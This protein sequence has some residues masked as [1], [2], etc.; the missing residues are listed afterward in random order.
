MSTLFSDK[1][2]RDVAAAATGRIERRRLLGVLAGVALLP[3]TAR[4]A[5][6]QP[7]AAP[8]G[9]ISS[10]ATLRDWSGQTPVRYPD[11]DIIALDPS[12][13][14]CMQFNSAI[15]RLH[16][17]TLWAEGPAWNGVGRYLVWSDIPNDVQMRWLEDDADVTRFRAPSN[18]SNGNTFDYQGRQLSAEHGGRR[19]VR[20]EAD[21]TVSVIADRYNGKRLNSPNDVVV[22]PD[23]SIWFTDPGFGIRSL[24]EGT[25]AESETKE[26]VY[27]VDGQSGAVALVTDEVGQPN[28]LCF[29]PDYTKLYV[30]D[31][32]QLKVWDIDGDKLRNARTFAMLKQ[33]DGSPSSADGIRCDKFGNVWAG[34]RPGVLVANPEGATIGVI[35]LPEVCAN[36]CFGGAKR[37]RLFMTAS[38]SLYSVYVGATGAHIC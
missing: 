1:R 26:A 4:T 19:V 36:L 33:P 28:G 29:S 24:Y 27:R 37:N 35:R 17:G 32:G 31:S 15:Q 5:F 30:A 38:Q 34:A 13:R 8:S 10:E 22:H 2:E 25:I 14:R 3:I 9:P 23:G 7:P 21:G 12:F 18:N 11:P 6:A 16:T 20:Y